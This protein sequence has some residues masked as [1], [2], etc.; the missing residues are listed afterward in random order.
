M[1]RP[2]F[3]EI[4]L[5]LAPFAVYALFLLATRAAVLEPDA[6]SWR[7]IGWLTGA[8]LLSVVLSFVVFAQFSGSAP[9]STYVPAHMEN[10][11]FVPG[12][13]E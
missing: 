12:R 3:T 7:V 9:G 5:F 4:A 1:I 2:V 8:A 6:W 10:G 13:T 11:V